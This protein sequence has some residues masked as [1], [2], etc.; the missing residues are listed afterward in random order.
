MNRERYVLSVRLAEGLQ[1]SEGPSSGYLRA[2]RRKWGRL[3]I[4]VDYYRLTIKFNHQL[5]AN[6][7]IIQ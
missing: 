7:V 4:K 6:M 5:L 1:P 3:T 2:K